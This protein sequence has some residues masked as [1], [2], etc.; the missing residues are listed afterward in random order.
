[1]K[2][3]KIKIKKKTK[4]KRSPTHAPT[5]GSIEW[6]KDSQFRDDGSLAHKSWTG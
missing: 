1:M 6:P 2:K 3:R 4:N 5:E